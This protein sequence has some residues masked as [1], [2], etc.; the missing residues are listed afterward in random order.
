MFDQGRNHIQSGE[1]PCSIRV[2]TMFNQGINH[3]RSGEKPCSIRGETTNSHE[4]VGGSALQ[5]AILSPA[6]VHSIWSLESIW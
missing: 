6:D 3:V 2:E 5:A 4:Q 1:K